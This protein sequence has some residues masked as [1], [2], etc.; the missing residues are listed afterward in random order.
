MKT[1]ISSYFSPVEQWGNLYSLSRSD[2]I[3]KKRGQFFTPIELADFILE[4]TGWPGS[5]DQALLDPACGPGVF[6]VAALRRWDAQITGRSN[7]GPTLWGVDKDPDLIRLARHALGLEAFLFSCPEKYKKINLLEGDALKIIPNTVD[8]MGEFPGLGSFQF[9]VGNPPYVGEKHNRDLF[10]DLLADCPYWQDSYMARADYS[11][12]FL[13]LGLRALKPGGRLGFIMPPYFRSASSTR[14]LRRELEG[15]AHILEWIDLYPKTPFVY[16]EGHQSIIVV[17][18]KKDGKKISEIPTPLVV[19]VCGPKKNKNSAPVPAEEWNVLGHLIDSV[20][21]T[22]PGTTK[23]QD[24]WEVGAVC[25]PIAPGEGAPWNLITRSIELIFRQ[26]W[27]GAGRPLSVHLEDRQGIVSGAD[28]VTKAHLRRFPQLEATV[29]EGIFYLTSA[30][31]KNLKLNEYEQTF[32]LPVILG[33]KLIANELLLKPL[34]RSFIIRIPKGTSIELLPNLKTHLARF[35]PILD[36]RREAQNGFIDWFGL[37][38]PRDSRRMAAPKLVCPRRASKNSFVFDNAQ[39]LVN[40]DCTFLTS[41]DLT[42]EDLLYLM[43]ML[44]SSACELYLSLF[45][46]RKGHI[47]EYYSEPLRTLPLPFKKIPKTLRKALAETTESSQ[48]S[49]SR[50]SEL[51]EQVYREVLHCPE[52]IL[53]ELRRHRAK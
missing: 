19:R 23:T 17:L 33:S 1:N 30:E 36:R 10:R 32:V 49:E 48:T 41:L 26:W 15:S 24:G 45:G 14:M 2:N 51:L 6:L 53:A 42:E 5:G 50:R 31:V 34:D 52:E 29:G 28:R 12:Y 44:N 39:N 21:G 46:K 13:L 37:H 25:A 3:R 18:Q 40:S 43:V 22:E 38:W 16:A 47:R 11:A 20:K 35:R 9:V 8:G 27:E 7:M 4:R